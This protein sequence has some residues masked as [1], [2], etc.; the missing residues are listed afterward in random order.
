MILDRIVEKKR[1]EVKVLKKKGI[2]LPVKCRENPIPPPRGFRE[3]LMRFEEVAIIAEA[4]KASPSKGVISP[5]FD[6]QKIVCS[7]EKE[8]AQAISVLTDEEFFQGCLEYLVTARE[9]VSLPILRKDFIIDELQIKEA[10]VHG[11]DG[12]L[13]IAAI[14][15]EQQIHD[16]F[17]YARELQM[18]VLVEVHNEAELEKAL[19]S[20]CD[21][22]G[23]NNRN[24]QDFSIDIETTFRLKELIPE[25]IPVVSESGL[26][27]AA[28]INR[29]K[30]HKIAAALIGESLMRGAGQGTTLAALRR[31]SHESL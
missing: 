18:D 16:Y 17:L 3:A 20:N 30:H 12:I 10:S 15:D 31:N 25:E 4:K 29:L 21:L 24:L 11:A 8:G 14:L 23:I 27:T 1:R 22:I 9:L 28:D 19:K 7:Y 26:S 5:D 2:E 13:L 6:I